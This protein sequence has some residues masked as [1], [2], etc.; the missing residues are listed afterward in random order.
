MAVACFALV[1]VLAGC[2]AAM[3]APCH[4]EPTANADGNEHH[5]L[6]R[7]G[8]APG[9]SDAIEGEA[10]LE[11]EM[12]G[13]INR[14]RAEHGVSPLVPD[15]SLTYVARYHALDMATFG[16]AGHDSP[17][18]GS[19]RDRLDRVGYARRLARE[20]AARSNTLQ[21]GHAN[22]LA[23]P[24]H[25]ANLLADDVTHVGIGIV[26]RAEGFYIVQAFAEPLDR[27]SPRQMETAIARRLQDKRR[28][29]DLPRLEHSGVLQIVAERELAKVRPELDPSDAD[30]ITQRAFFA[31]Q[32]AADHPGRADG[33]D[34]LELRS[35]TWTLLRATRDSASVAIPVSAMTDESTA[36]AIA[37]RDAVTAEGRPIALVVILFG[38]R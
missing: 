16:Y 23:S 38:G 9:D 35:V 4:F 17:R 8:G 34:G 11:V 24:G 20:N 12:L 22:F 13:L 7:F 28:G 29:A 18:T 19:Y 1:A 6:P 2:G 26:E 25:R 15:P 27:E 36:F 14:A 3:N 31:L 32:C 33:F 10:E 5:A 37:A 21:S 30:R